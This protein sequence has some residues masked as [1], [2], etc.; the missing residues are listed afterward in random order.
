MVADIVRYTVSLLVVADPVFASLY[1]VVLAPEEQ[2]PEIARRTS[3][4]VLFSFV[5]TVAFGLSILD[6][7]GVSLASVKI[8]GGAILLQMA[9]QMLQAKVP[10]QKRTD[11]EESA[12]TEKVDISFIPLG[13]PIIFG[14]GVLTTTLIFRSEV[15]SIGDA[16]ALIASVLIVVLLVYIFLRNGY[17]LSSKIGIT[18]IGTFTRVMGLIVGALGSQFVVEGVKFLW[19][20]KEV[21]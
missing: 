16:V 1:L 13:I 5:L 19:K 21:V 2:I 4:V 17:R 8:F 12:A 11:R 14:P 6:L 20:A 18:G 15:S 3:I 9:F 7:L 10:P